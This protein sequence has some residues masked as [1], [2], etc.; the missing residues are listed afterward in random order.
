MAAF[1]PSTMVIVSNN[2]EVEP[3]LEARHPTIKRNPLTEEA[4]RNITG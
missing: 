1:R 4:Y 3:M 2:P